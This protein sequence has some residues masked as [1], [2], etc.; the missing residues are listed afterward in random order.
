MFLAGKLKFV[1]RGLF[2]CLRKYDQKGENWP[3]MYELNGWVWRIAW[4]MLS[5]LLINKDWPDFGFNMLFT[6]KSATCQG[7][8]AGGNSG[9]VLLGRAIKLDWL[10]LKL[11]H[12][13]PPSEGLY[14]EGDPGQVCSGG[15][16]VRYWQILAVVICLPPCRCGVFF[17]VFGATEEC[18]CCVIFWVRLSIVWLYNGIQ[19]GGVYEGCYIW[20][21]FDVAEERELCICVLGGMI[22][23]DWC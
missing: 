11:T 12:C 4:G 15:G 8:Y 14:F 2:V 3:Y 21:Y 17:C 5:Y 23:H 18:Y 16:L 22:Y 1:L 20:G 10:D 9:S 6:P 7:L 13:L 19:P